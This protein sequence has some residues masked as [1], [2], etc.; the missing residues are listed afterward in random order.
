M[1]ALRLLVDAFRNGLAS[2]IDPIQGS[3]GAGF[4]QWEEAELKDLTESVGLQN[5]DRVRDNRFIL[6]SATKPPAGAGQ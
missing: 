1:A 5:L 4:K 3:S 2:Q 6:F